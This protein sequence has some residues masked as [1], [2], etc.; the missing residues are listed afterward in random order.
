MAGSWN[1]LAVIQCFSCLF[2]TSA[3]PVMVTFDI[4]LQNR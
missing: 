1:H 2:D 4:H 3:M